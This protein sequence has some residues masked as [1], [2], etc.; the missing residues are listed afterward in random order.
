MFRPHGNT[1]DHCGV[2]GTLIKENIGAAMY[3]CYPVDATDKELA[4][5]WVRSKK[6]DIIQLDAHR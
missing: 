1:A 5:M 3:I 4:T 6:S 2:E